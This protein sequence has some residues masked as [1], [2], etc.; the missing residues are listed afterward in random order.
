MEGIILNS[1]DYPI[2]T[3]ITFLPLAGA[4]VILFL[5]REAIVKWFALA[6]T[7]TTFVVSLPVY[8]H[9]DKVTYK[10]Q[11]AEIYPWIPAWNINYKVGV[12]GISILFIILVTILS[13]LCVS[14]SWKAIQIKTKSFIYLF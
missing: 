1:L 13:I 4:F 7:M 8:K 12:D 10:M 9:F 6:T 11:F 3:V 14:V 2:L 5:R